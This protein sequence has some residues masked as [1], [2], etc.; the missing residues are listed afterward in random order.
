M[1]ITQVQLSRDLG[2]RQSGY[3]VCGAFGDMG[4]LLDATAVVSMGI[5]C[6]GHGQ[7]EFG[8]AGSSIGCS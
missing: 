6:G 7:G 8:E 2:G 5:R 1:G 4:D 3:G